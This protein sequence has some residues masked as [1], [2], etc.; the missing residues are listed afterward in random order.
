M[1]RH[2]RR[3]TAARLRALVLPLLFLAPTIGCNA[4][5]LVG[6]T[7]RGSGTIVSETRNVGPITSIEIIGAM[8]A[9]VSPGETPSLQI[10]ADDNILPLIKTEVRN[11]R[12]VARVEFQ[13]S[14]NPSKPI[15]LTVTTPTLNGIAAHGAS[16]IDATATPGEQFAIEVSGASEV[17]V[18]AIDVSTLVVDISGAGKAQVSG[19]AN[20]VTLSNSGASNLDATQL[21]S[22][23]AKVNLSGASTAEVVVSSS[24]T[25]DLSGASRL[26]VHGNPAK[27]DLETS[28][29]SNLSFEA[30]KTLSE[31]E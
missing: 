24:I 3:A 5:A 26:R 10:E 9:R 23:S 2:S 6:P 4:L 20:T 17:R 22:E 19:Q 7:L 11:G 18:D 29:A 21:K 12:L 8:Q 25:G 27:R 30:A 13:G 15:A 28:G 16:K 14:I 1:S 31:K